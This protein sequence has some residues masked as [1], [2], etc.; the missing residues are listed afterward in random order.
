MIQ[1]DGVGLTIAYRWID[2]L[3][4]LNLESYS[5]LDIWLGFHLTSTIEV[6]LVGQNL[7]GSYH[8]E[9]APEFYDTVPTRVEREFYGAIGWAF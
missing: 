3:P 7:L 4:G 8:S 6:S 9:F 1:F 5:A 2:E